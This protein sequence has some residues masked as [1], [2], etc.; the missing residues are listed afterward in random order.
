M[1]PLTP[2]QTEVAALVAD[3]LTDR[4]IAERL[5]VSIT[6]V[7]AHVHEIMARGGLRNRVQVAVAAVLML[8]VVPSW[9]G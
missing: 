5:S 9:I 6:T 1:L 4:E 8:G 2:R 3:G 7:Y